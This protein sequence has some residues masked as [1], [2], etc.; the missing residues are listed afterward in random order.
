MDNSLLIAL[1]ALLGLVVGSF[2]NVVIY[3]LPRIIEQEWKAELDAYLKEQGISPP[4]ATT[5]DNALTAKAMPQSLSLSLP[6]SHCPHCQTPIRYR[7]LI[8][9]LSW[10]FRRG[11]CAHC[12][13]RIGLRYPIVELISAALAVIAWQQV[14][15]P[16]LAAAIYGFSMTLVVG[17]LIDWDSQ[18]LPDRITL[19]LMWSGL[20]LASIGQ[21]PLGLSLSHSLWGAM[22]GYLTFWLMATVFRLVT[23]RD[24][25][26][27][28]DTKLLAALGAWLGGLVLPQLL[29]MSSLLGLG[30]ALWFRLR[31]G[32]QG[33]FPFGPA[34][35]ASGLILFWHPLPL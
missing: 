23:G 17:A 33:E 11:R 15:T 9:V 12:Q 6:R 25:L 28:G 24:G 22:A 18:W 20:F 31:E 16:L 1:I 2:A 27:G 26:G 32:K 10:L 8:P 7:D 34:L 30:I 5:A 14:Q 19:P 4:M 29:L 13:G 3:R 21:N 35:A